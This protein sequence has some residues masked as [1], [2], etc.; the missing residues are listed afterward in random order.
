MKK[1]NQHSH[2]GDIVY[3]PLPGM[4]IVILNSYEAAQEL[5]SKR[6]NSTSGRHIGYLVKDL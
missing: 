2:K 4:S 1:A 3:A 6:P 5:L